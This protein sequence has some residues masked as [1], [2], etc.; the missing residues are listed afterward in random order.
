MEFANG[1]NLKKFA[2]TEFDNAVKRKHY[3]AKQRVM[4]MEIFDSTGDEVP[5]EVV[6]EAGSW[7]DA[8]T[9]VT[10]YGVF[11]GTNKTVDNPITLQMYTKDIE[12]I[13]KAWG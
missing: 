13:S 11:W 10:E 1:T 8:A 12:D 2:C 4:I 9:T 7:L 3:W 6:K 5:E